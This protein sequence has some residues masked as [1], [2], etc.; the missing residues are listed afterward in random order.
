MAYAPH[1]RLTLVGTL[2][3]A[4]APVENFS[5][6]VCLSNANG[7]GRDAQDLF[8]DYVADTTAF[9]GRGTT[10]ISQFAILR[11][12]KL[13]KIGEDGKYTSDPR[14]A[15]VT[16]PGFATGSAPLHPYQVALAVSLGTNRRGPRGKGRFYLPCPQVSMTADG[17]IPSAER[18]FIETS[19]AEW[20]TDLNNHPS[21]DVTDAEVVVAS[22]FGFNSKVTSVRVGRVL[23]TVRSRR[24]NLDEAYGTA[25]PVS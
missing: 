14:I 9:W 12:I 15:S 25:T 22:S 3:P 13:A 11:E 19:V 16:V 4:S 2:G 21:V 18:D 17:L 6:R 10:G 8:D 5:L 1:Q 7:I 23:D 20:I 24:R